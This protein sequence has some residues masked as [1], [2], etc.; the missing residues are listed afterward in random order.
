MEL[1]VTVRDHTTQLSVPVHWQRSGNTLEANG[2][3]SFTQTALGLE[4]YSLLFGAL[5]VSDEIQ[6][7]F[8]LVARTS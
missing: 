3:F 2:E 7:R 5:R 1:T 6:A 4:P 8:R